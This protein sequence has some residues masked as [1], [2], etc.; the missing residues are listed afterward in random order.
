MDELP[1]LPD[2]VQVFEGP[3]LERTDVIETKFDEKGDIK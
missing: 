3:P 1:E 2:D